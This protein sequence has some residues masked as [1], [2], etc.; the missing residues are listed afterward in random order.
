MLIETPS[1]STIILAPV[2]SDYMECSNTKMFYRIFDG[3]I[4]ISNQ[5]L[6]LGW[7]HALIISLRTQHIPIYTKHVC[8][9]ALRLQ[10]VRNIH[11]QHRHTIYIR[12]IYVYA[13]YVYVTYVCSIN[14]TYIVT[15]TQYMHTPYIRALCIKRMHDR[16][17][18]H[19]YTDVCVPYMHRR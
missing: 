17:T 3:S 5:S 15:V 10:Y 1:G 18:Q 9:C 19:M 7:Q 13:Q 16:C 2:T 14:M 6:L 8:M 12:N 4:R 11:I